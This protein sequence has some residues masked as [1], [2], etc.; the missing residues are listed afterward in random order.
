M[1]GKTLSAKNQIQPRRS[2]ISLSC[3][4]ST[5]IYL[6]RVTFFMLSVSLL[7]SKSM[8]SNNLERECEILEARLK[9]LTGPDS[10]KALTELAN[11]YQE[12]SYVKSMAWSELLLQKA[13]RSFDTVFII[14]GLYQ[15]GRN[16]YLNADYETS[17]NLYLKAA[18]L[19]DKALKDDNL[20][21]SVYTRAAQSL[22]KASEPDSGFAFF[23]KAW[24]IYSENGNTS[25]QV[26]VLISLAGEYYQLKFFGESIKLYHLCK[27][28]LLPG[29]RTLIAAQ[30]YRYYA[31]SK[32]LTGYPDEALEIA[33]LAGQIFEELGMS[34]R[35]EQMSRVYGQIYF[36]MGLTEKAINY[37]TEK[38]A[39]VHEMGYLLEASYIYNQLAHYLQQKEKH[40]QA[41]YYQRKA[42]R[43][44]ESI[45]YDNPLISAYINYGDVLHKSGN[46]DSVSYYLR[47]GLELAQRKSHKP[48]IIRACNKLGHFYESTGRFD[49]SLSF[50][51]QAHEFETSEALQ[52]TK[53]LRQLL[54]LKIKS[55]EY[56]E[57]VTRLKDIEQ[58]Q[59]RILISL[60]GL[61]ILMA[62]AIAVYYKNRRRE[63]NVRMLELKQKLIL[64]QLN[65]SFIFNALSAIKGFIQR[66]QGDEAGKYL[67]GFARLIREVLV[68]P[69]IDYH[70]LEKETEIMQNYLELQKIRF[71]AYFSFEVKKD[72]AIYHG[73][74]VIPPFLAYPLIDAF[75]S[76]IPG[77]IEQPFGMTVH[78]S[79]TGDYLVQT[80]HFKLPTGLANPPKKYPH[81]EGAE[82]AIRLIRERIRLLN[83][84][85]RRN[86]YF[87][88]PTAGEGASE[89]A[90]TFEIGSPS[91]GLSHL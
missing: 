53:R 77:N 32:S 41:L 24:M 12:I 42:L 28:I 59:I 14:E 75:F 91:L 36:E 43:L 13:T 52:S 58:T 81:F 76:A 7:F 78:F 73:R 15:L 4:Q 10:L 37:L 9:Y 20:R 68:S 82:Q 45:G 49:Q 61:V 47:L 1:T 44:R 40:E 71:G 55:Q 30:A 84:G 23:E 21:A 48:D 11:M 74:N 72:E 80:C 88:R 51:Q 69:Q 62:T 38:A 46:N 5:C 34:L 57:K 63:S 18:G 90:I 70:L 60:I 86:P 3:V 31:V 25:G 56:M 65:P 2:L 22:M 50:L 16:A 67:S 85:T 33:N 83:S 39:K 64:T 87:F 35:V 26:T 17:K 27:N 19:S 79:L 6:L 89:S 66:N 29:Q 54:T 8:L